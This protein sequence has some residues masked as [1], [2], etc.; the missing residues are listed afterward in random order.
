[1]EECRAS[2]SYASTPKALDV[3]ASLG[4][5]VTVSYDSDLDAWAETPDLQ[6]TFGNVSRP[7]SI[8]D[9]RVSCPTPRLPAY[10]ASINMT[11][12]PLG[13]GSSDTDLSYTFEA[14]VTV[15]TIMPLRGPAAGQHS[16]IEGT[17]LAATGRRSAG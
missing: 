4:E 16:D 14:P 6:C 15:S 12:V 10:M 9:G 7:A 17:G 8:V 11:E 13:V 5:S 3:N 2:L 1:M